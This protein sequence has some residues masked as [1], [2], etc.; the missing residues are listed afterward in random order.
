M[1]KNQNFGFSKNRQKSCLIFGDFWAKKLSPKASENCQNG[2]K[3]PHLVTLERIE[4]KQFLDIHGSTQRC[5][6]TREC[7]N[8]KQL[9]ERSVLQNAVGQLRRKSMSIWQ[10]ST[11]GG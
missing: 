8:E 4:R 7:T 5:Q 2:D 1:V 6:G 9:K 11:N 3:S 10:Y